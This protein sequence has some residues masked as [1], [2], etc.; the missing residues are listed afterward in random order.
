VPKENAG[1]YIE[2][3]QLRRVHPAKESASSSQGEHAQPRRAHLANENAEK[4]LKRTLGVP[5]EGTGEHI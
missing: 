3:I 2:R 5:K 4:C 1:E